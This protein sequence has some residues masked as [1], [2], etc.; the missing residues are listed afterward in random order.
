VQ[1][2][3]QPLAIIVERIWP[4]LDDET[5]AHLSDEEITLVETAQKLCDDASKAAVQDRLASIERRA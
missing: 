4:G 2:E 3:E 1:A 5:R